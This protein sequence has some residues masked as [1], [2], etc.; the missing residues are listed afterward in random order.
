[1]MRL[2]A[3]KRFELQ[4]QTAGATGGMPLDDTVQLM[5]LLLKMRER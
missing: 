1:M 2:W 5:Q 3:A 4:W